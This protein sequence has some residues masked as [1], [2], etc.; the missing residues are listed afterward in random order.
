MP[1]IL[2]ASF[3]EVPAPKGAS[4]HILAVIR[5]LGARF[6]DVRLVTPSAADRPVA[7]LAEGVTH[8]VVG[9]PD[10]NPIGRAR[11]FQARLRRLLERESY[12]VLHF[13]SPWEGLALIDPP[14]RRGAR[15]LYEVNGFPSIELKYHYRALLDDEYLTDKLR[16]QELCCLQAADRIVTVSDVNRRE[17]ESRGISPAKITVVRNGVEPSEFHFQG[18]RELSPGEPLRVAYFGTMTVWQGVETLIEAVT[19][20]ARDRPV[21]LE[22]QGAGGR[23]RARDLQRLAERL[24]SE[25]IVKFRPAGD[26]T[27]IVDLLHRS[28]V[29]AIPLLAVDR[30]VR[31]GCCPLKLLEAMSAGTPVIASDLPVV[32]ELAEPDRHFLPA[33]A[34]DARNLKNGLL[35]LAV[36]PELRAALSRAAREHVTSH[37][38]WRQSLDALADVYEKLLAS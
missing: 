32:R 23:G 22:I 28:H 38:T 13:R 14:L 9:C 34:G 7:P 29:A 4:T 3:D 12:D 37:L 36:E 10:D 24:G 16:Q 2:Y 5:E 8:E 26:Q 30:N 18:A 11:T 17:I 35:R 1:R 33:R 21:M 15:V 6:G 20:A 25:S 31:Q 19:L 27:A